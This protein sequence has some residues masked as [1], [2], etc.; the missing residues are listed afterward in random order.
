MYGH[1][2]GLE[3]LREFKSSYGERL[4][5]MQLANMQGV[6]Q[7]F[8][9]FSARVRSAIIGSFRPLLQARTLNIPLCLDRDF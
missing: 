1:V 7:T 4:L 6:E 3:L 8:R 5:S 9:P 2:L